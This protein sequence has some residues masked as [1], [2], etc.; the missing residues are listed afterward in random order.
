MEEEVR[1]KIV[2]KFKK[3]RVPTFL[4]L[5][6]IS[7]EWGPGSSCLPGYGSVIIELKTKDMQIIVKN[8]TF[9]ARISLVVSGICDGKSVIIS[10]QIICN[11]L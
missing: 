4:R 3:I 11:V 9:F 5:P 8:P 2:K 1:E 10:L 6:R 7:G